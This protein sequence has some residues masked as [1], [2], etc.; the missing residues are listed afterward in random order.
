MN[1]VIDFI[2][3]T[4]IIGVLFILFLLLRRKQINLSQ[5]ILAALFIVLFFVI[6]GFYSNL[7]QLKI[8]H[9]VSFLFY[10]TAGYI[11]GPLFYLYIK[12]LFQP[13]QDLLRKNWKHF[14]PTLLIL[15][16]WNIPALLSNY[17]GAFIFPYLKILAKNN[18]ELIET[19]LQLLFFIFYCVLS[20]RLLKQYRKTL[21]E[22]Y[23]TL[24]DKDLLWA[25]YLIIGSLIAMSLNGVLMI[26][27]VSFGEASWNSD[28]LTAFPLAIMLVYLG[29]HGVLQSQVL[30]PEFINNQPIPE[31]VPKAK[32]PI[33]KHPLT[34]VS[35]AK[36][37]TIKHPL[38]NVPEMEIAK[39]KERLM[40][41]LEKEKPYLNEELTLGVLANLIPTSDKKLS[42]LLNHYVKAT[43]YNFINSYR[44]TEV[45]AKIAD[46]AYAHYTLLAIGLHC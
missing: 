2:L 3:V 36:E 42:A 32:E 30:L 33:I 25:K 27:Q 12:S 19:V 29:Y 45:K 38:T 24:V 41:V 28:N 26:L 13:T 40:E 37:P 8:I 4:S 31:T 23:S 20:L 46:D 18:F 7:H 14:I 9:Y 22:N 15:L 21:K 11:A 34:N 1:L 44:I 17:K 6:T 35:K 43:F 5:K 16:L 39:L 10:F